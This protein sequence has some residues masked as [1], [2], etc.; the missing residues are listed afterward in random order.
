MPQQFVI[1]FLVIQKKVKDYYSKIKDVLAG[2]TVKKELN[3]LQVDKEAAM[4]MIKAA[5]RQEPGQK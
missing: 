3:P 1:Y 2:K 4:R 5:I